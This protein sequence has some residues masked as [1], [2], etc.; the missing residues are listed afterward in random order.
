MIALSR[1]VFEEIQNV[2]QRPKFR[3]YLSDDDRQEILA[4]LTDAAIWVAP[5]I[6]V[7]DC[8]DSRDNM[9]LELAAA[10]GANV[11]ISSDQDLLVLDPWRGVRIVRQAEYPGMI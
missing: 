10:T 6:R 9:Y 7:T 3:H 8:R 11:L 2:L 5:S 4:L 1:P